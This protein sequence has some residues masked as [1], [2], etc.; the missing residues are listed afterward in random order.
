MRLAV[1][2]EVNV[3]V[4]KPRQDVSSVKVD[5]FVAG[6]LAARR[7][8][9]DF[10]VA[11]ENVKPLRRA[12]VLVARENFSVY[13]SVFHFYTPSERTQSFMSASEARFSIF[14]GLKFAVGATHGFTHAAAAAR[15]ERH[16]RF[17]RK[18]IAFEER[19][20]NRGR[21]VP[22]DGEAHENHVV[23]RHVR[24]LFRDCRARRGVVHLH[25]AAALLVRPIE[26]GCG[27]R[28]FGLNLE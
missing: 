5:D 9:L 15:C 12:H 21:D 18:I 28:H 7:H 16:D 25:G 19:V 26:V 6:V 8:V 4:D 17:A 27:V 23:V 22:P 24:Q 20:Y 13:K 11:N 14:P 3:H 1:A 2:G 10:I